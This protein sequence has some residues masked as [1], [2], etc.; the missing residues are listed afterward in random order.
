MNVLSPEDR[1]LLKKCLAWAQEH[2]HELD[3]DQAKW[4]E[5]FT[6]WLD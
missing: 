1:E 4:R 5:V 3:D 2:E 6:G